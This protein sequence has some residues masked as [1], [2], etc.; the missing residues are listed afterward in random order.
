VLDWH[1]VQTCV[2]HVR[3]LRENDKRAP[4]REV[5]ARADKVSQTPGPRG[6]Q[7]ARAGNVPAW[8]RIGQAAAASFRCAACGEMAGVVK[9]G[10]A[11]TTVDVGPPLG[12]ETYDRDAIVADYFLG[13]ASKFADAATLD[14]VQEVVASATPDPV[15]LRRI[16]WELTAFYWI[17][18]RF[19]DR[20]PA[21]G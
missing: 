8:G 12:R 9:V 7:G 10:R 19:R 4:V 13:T 18:P 1:V 15:A 6:R 20:E 2:D 21:R 14:A 3:E 11:G 16:D 5:R 17:W